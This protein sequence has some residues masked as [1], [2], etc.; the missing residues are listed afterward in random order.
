MKAFKSA[1]LLAAC[2]STLVSCSNN[3]DV[4]NDVK[5]PLEGSY[6][7]VGMKANTYA[8]VEQRYSDDTDVYKTITTSDYDAKDLAGT[9]VID[10][11][12]FNSSKFKYTINTNV[13]GT[14]Y[15]NG[16]ESGYSNQPWNYPVPE[17]SGSSTYKLVGTDSISFTGGFVIS[18]VF[19]EDP[20]PSPA[21]GAKYKW[22]GD[23]LVIASDFRQLD[24]TTLTDQGQSMTMYSDKR[25]TQI[26]RLKKN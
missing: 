10:A 5:N 14:I 18:P 2:A 8:E 23:T 9:V 6:T 11:A 25:S 4:N 21:Y 3:D 19:G 26:M 15:T 16:E 17:S 12:R 7:F 13:I 1:L 22:E 24:T 20:A